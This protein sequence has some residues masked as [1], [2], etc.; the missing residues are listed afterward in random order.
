MFS[1]AVICIIIPYRARECKPNGAGSR[2][3]WQKPARKR[4]APPA[5][6]AIISTAAC[7]RYFFR[8]EEEMKFK[9][10]ARDGLP[11]ALGYLSVAFAYAVQAAGMGFPPW[12]PVLVSFTNFTGTGQFAGTEL[13]AQ[14]A[15]FAVLAAT[16]LV[17]NLRYALMS[18]SLSQKMGDGF[19]L[20]QRAVLA[21]G[22]TDENYAVAM[23][24]P[25]KLTFLYLLGLMSCSF[26]GWVGGTAL[27][28]GVSAAIGRLVGGEWYAALMGAL[29]IA[30]YAMFVAIILPPAREDARVLLLVALSVGASCLFAFVPALADLPEGIDIIV[31]SVACTA[32]LS[33]LFPRGEG[34]DGLPAPDKTAGGTPG[35]GEGGAQ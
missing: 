15:N 33:F 29:G 1:V 8:T 14:G 5:F 16:M 24:Q 31:C 6:C 9:N 28:A 7:G 18:L 19:P 4:Y 32:L 30:L 10:G 34:E 3:K 11:I 26:A 22:V 2:E 13:I 17:I 20:W 25:K 12:F 27:G 35:E 21:F 23:R